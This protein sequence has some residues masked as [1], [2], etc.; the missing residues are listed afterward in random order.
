MSARLFAIK[1]Q[2]H[3]LIYLLRIIKDMHHIS[4][5]I[6]H[7]RRITQQVSRA[8]KQCLFRIQQIML[9]SLRLTGRN[10]LH[11]TVNKCNLTNRHKYMCH[12]TLL[13]DFPTS[14]KTVAGDIA[15]VVDAEIVVVEEMEEEATVEGSRQLNSTK[16][17]ISS[18][19]Q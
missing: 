14:I 5:T 19:K 16:T 1:W 15:D 8:S 7:S 10:L 6:Q 12:Q 18:S 13:V 9:T 4:T 2:R 11:N 3:C 17:D